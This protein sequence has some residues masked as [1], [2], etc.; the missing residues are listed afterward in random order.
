LVLEQSAFSDTVPVPVRFEQPPA[1]DPN[2]LRDP[3]TLD[4]K[5]NDQMPEA[6]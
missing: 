6:Q 2:A 1:I 5:P 4:Q 3:R